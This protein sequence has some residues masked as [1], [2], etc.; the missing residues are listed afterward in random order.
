VVGQITIPK[1]EVVTHYVKANTEQK[2]KSKVQDRY[3]AELVLMI[4]G[5]LTVNGFS[6]LKDRF[7]DDDV[8]DARSVNL[9]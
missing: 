1:R 6:V 2:A 5:E 9:A 8:L 3:P 7:G 4:A